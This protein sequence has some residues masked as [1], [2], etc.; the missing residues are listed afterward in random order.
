MEPIDVA[1]DRGIAIL[2]QLLASNI[3]W[4]GS[5]EF[6]T[7][8]E[9]VTPFHKAVL[10]HALLHGIR[11]YAQR[12][13]LVREQSATQHWPLGLLNLFNASVVLCRRFVVLLFGWLRTQTLQFAMSS[14]PW[15]KLRYRGL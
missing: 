13:A 2:H 9:P 8:A 4:E 10:F 14:M 6:Y 5:I 12:S 3:N 7:K 15:N 1:E 11:P